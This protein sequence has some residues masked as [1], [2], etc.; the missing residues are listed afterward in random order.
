MV[1]LRKHL[2]IHPDDGH[3]LDEMAVL[4]HQAGQ[5]AAAVECA[6]RAADARPND[7]IVH[8]HLGLI[9]LGAA[10]PNDAVVAAR[11]A[12]ALAP[13]RGEFHLNLGNALLAADDAT[14]AVA[15]F[16]RAVA[17]LPREPLAWF[18]CGNALAR[19]GRPTDAT[20][21]L[22]RALALR[23]QFAAARRNLALLLHERGDTSA[24]LALL[25]P[26]FTRD[27]PELLATVATLHLE[28][29]DPAAALPPLERA[30]Q[31][32]PDDPANH[33]GL[34]C[35]LR[36]L[37]RDAEAA[38][39]CET[40]LRLAPH[41]PELW[42]QLGLASADPAAAENAFRRVLEFSPDHADATI[43]L[44][45]L[46]VTEERATEAVALLARLL[47]TQPA[48]IDLLCAHAFALAGTGEAAAALATLRRAVAL[49]PRHAQAQWLL[50]I[51]E[52][53]T[54][55]PGAGW[56]GYE[57]RWETDTRGERRFASLPP[58]PA[59]SPR[60]GHLLVWGEQG[61]GD[62]IMFASLVPALAARVDRVT[63]ACTP[64]FV[65]L[66]VRSFPGLEVVAEPNSPRD[67]PP[68]TAADWQLAAGS[69][70]A[71][72]Q[73][74]PDGARP[75][76]D[77]PA[78]LADPARVATLR[79]R[80]R[81]D[82]RPTVGLAWRTGNRRNGRARSIPP[83]VWAEALRSLPFRFISLQYGNCTAELAAAAAAGLDVFADPEI[84]NWNDL[85]GFAAQIAALDAVLTIDNST[86]H[87]AGALG[88]P[89]WLLVPTPADWRWRTSGTTTPW[90]DS[91]RIH[92]R[93]PG[94]AWAPV[95]AAANA[96]L[97]AFLVS[98]ANSP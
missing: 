83:P 24:A 54:G 23:P 72:L 25:A 18:N 92:R 66:F 70:P 91:V 89:T 3:A 29:D 58:W 11:R 79:A 64:R 95:L 88:R 90:Y 44:S 13:R 55:E 42:N 21:R 59:D 33:L 81:V 87:F 48:N 80:Y 50:A 62:E 40:G 4:F 12:I 1:A 8:D 35:C 63:L 85:D 6:S 26:E 76:R 14:A 47:P 53:A 7:P 2:R 17:L 31:L 75:R 60:H 15:A 69:V 94:G 5:P 74:S 56:A 82:A 43:N 71:R 97:Q 67:P 61:V 78:L 93:P 46:L 73:A 77:R 84:D 68:A 22:E 51:A 32:A 9:L 36:R 30:V 41:D 57:W 16:E 38:A 65:P 28:R 37:G 98:S 39:A 45:R 34:A 27:S 86:V 96:E 20:A 19:A 49:A 10:R 52:L